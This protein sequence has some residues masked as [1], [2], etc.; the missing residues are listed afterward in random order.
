MSHTSKLEEID[1]EQR[2][3]EAASQQQPDNQAFAKPMV[4]ALNPH[5]DNP[6]TP[7]LAQEEIEDQE[8][9]RVNLT[10]VV[11][12]AIVAACATVIL[13]VAQPWKNGN[14]LQPSTPAVVE[15]D[16]AVQKPA[17]AEK[18]AEKPAATQ[19][20]Q[21]AETQ[22]PA[23]KP[24][25]QKE[26]AATKTDDKKEV[27]KPTASSLPVVQ[28]TKTGTSNVYNNI[29]LIDASSRLLT[30]SEVE[31][32]T[33]EELALAR[34]SIYARHGY[35]F[36]NPDLKEFFAKQSWFKATD[37]KIDAIPFTQTELDNIRLIKAQE[38]K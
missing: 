23:E 25:Q 36:N 27:V 24:E 26:P 4:E 19:K 30:K 8:P 33:K 5:L 34:N 18:S 14:D 15:A 38:Q 16:T 37:V 21:P 32:M 22:K 12:T 20:Q 2:Q 1:K 6:T 17:A 11:C 35:Q 31:Q 9:P 29:R 28:T 10:A 13:L 3:Q 7:L